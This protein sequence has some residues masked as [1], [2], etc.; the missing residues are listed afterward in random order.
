M[1]FG[2]ELMF[3]FVSVP[4]TFHV[5]PQNAISYEKRDV[6][7]R[8]QAEGQPK[9][10]ITWYKNGNKIEESDYFVIVDGQD[11]RILGLLM[12]DSG[13][14]QCFVENIAGSIQ[15]TIQLSVRQQGMEL[16]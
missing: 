3:F 14:Y 13:F 6:T 9:P 5:H 11:L 1:L 12:L 7:L 8:C 4:P 2:K 16:L 10:Q 15:A